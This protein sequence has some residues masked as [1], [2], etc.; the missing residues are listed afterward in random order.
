[1][2][3]NDL[4]RKVLVETALSDPHEVAVEVTRRLRGAVALREALAEALVVYVRTSFT[5]DLMRPS[6]VAVDAVSSAKVA[7][8]RSQW[9]RRLA[10][11]V[12]VDGGWKRLGACTADDLRAVAASLRVHADQTAAK[13]DYYEA[14]AS[15]LP[16][17]AVVADLDADPMAVA[18]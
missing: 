16:V 12:V 15:V 9:Q 11:P 17:G 3:L 6:A 1:M 5:R 7:A 8:C 18:A 2:S 4:V 13:A 14:L 10:T